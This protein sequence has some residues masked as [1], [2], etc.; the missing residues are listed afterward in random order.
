MH[1]KLITHAST[2]VGSATYLAPA[3]IA[4]QACGAH[5]PRAPNGLCGPF[6]QLGILE[7]FSSSTNTVVELQFGWRLIPEYCHFVYP[8]E[9]LP[10]R[11]DDGD[12]LKH[13]PH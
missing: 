13:Q 8:I 10:A 6:Q 2:F 11:R 5:I 3:T 4:V 7:D 9:L 12:P 1:W